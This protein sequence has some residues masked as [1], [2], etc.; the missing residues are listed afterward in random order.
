[1]IIIPLGEGLTISYVL[2]MLGFVCGGYIA[3]QVTATR[4]QAN[5]TVGRPLRNR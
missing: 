1:M 4:R 2:F 5:K 3:T